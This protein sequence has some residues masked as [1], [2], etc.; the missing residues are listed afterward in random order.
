MTFLNKIQFI[1]LLL[2]STQS[3]R[4][5]PLLME[6]LPRFK[7]LS[8]S[9]KNEEVIKKMIFFLLVLYCYRDLSFENEYLIR[10]ASGLMLTLIQY[11]T[12]KSLLSIFVG[13]FLYMILMKLSQNLGL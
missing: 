8:P 2:L 4:L 3:T 6:K 5:L 7:S 13:T 9:I 12:N 10:L 1:S 11:K